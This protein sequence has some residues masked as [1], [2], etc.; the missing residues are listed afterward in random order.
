MTHV[1]SADPG[2]ERL[3]A[4]RQAEKRRSLTAD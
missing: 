2:L 4:E 3:Q 1:N